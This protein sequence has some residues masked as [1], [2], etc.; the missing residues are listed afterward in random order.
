MPG[1]I[2][3]PILGMAVYLFLI[4]PRLS[5]RGEIQPFLGT[6]WAHRGFHCIEN[7]VPENSMAAFKMAVKKGCGIELDVHLTKDKKLVVF[8]DDTLE[9]MCSKPGIIEELS[10]PELAKCYLKGTSEK[11]P[12]LK[13]V[14]AYVKGRVPLLIEIKLPSKNTEICVQLVKV[15]QEYTGP[16]LVQSFNCLSLRWLKKYE[17]DIL[18][19]QLS[20]N[21]V[22]SDKAP[23]RFV[24]FCVKHLLTNFICRPDF[25]SYKL[26]DTKNIS[27]WI[28]NKALSVPV[29]VWTIRAGDAM[30]RAKETFD[31]YIFE[32]LGSRCS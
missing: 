6:R 12:L 3:V 7:G 13:D 11:I 23:H 30:K 9:R 29:A 17:G 21:L 8:H 1:I 20:S 28:L 31:M 5:R 16:F 26:E 4:M 25:I 24:R 14:L 19:G 18:R 15:L 27:L 2:L 22:K 10:Y 32:R